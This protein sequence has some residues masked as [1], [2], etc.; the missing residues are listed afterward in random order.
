MTALE[1]LKKIAHANYIRKVAEFTYDD[2]HHLL[3]SVFTEYVEH[4][5]KWLT[6][7]DNGTPRTALARNLLLTPAARLAWSYGKPSVQNI[8]TF[9]KNREIAFQNLMRR[10]AGPTV[11]TYVDRRTGNLLSDVVPPLQVKKFKYKSLPHVPAKHFSFAASS[12]IA[13]VLLDYLRLRNRP[14]PSTGVLEIPAS[15]NA[16]SL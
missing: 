15:T 13:G 11:R 14:V 7:M 16:P 5:V 1:N 4:P 12:G 3:P 2:G 6:G 8:G 9:T 10:K